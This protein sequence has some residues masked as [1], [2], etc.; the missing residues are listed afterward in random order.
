MDYT[1]YT[2]PKTKTA[3]GFNPQGTTK[4]LN[5]QNTKTLNHQTTKTLKH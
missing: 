3:K 4:T 5:H 2:T 1:F